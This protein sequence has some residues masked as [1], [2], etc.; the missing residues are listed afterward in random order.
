MGPGACCPRRFGFLEVPAMALQVD[1]PFAAFVGIDL[2]GMA[3]VAPMNG[4]GEFA[5]KRDFHF[6]IVLDVPFHFRHPH[7]YRLF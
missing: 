6:W 4:Y 7:Y 5:I 3:L 1:V 2:N